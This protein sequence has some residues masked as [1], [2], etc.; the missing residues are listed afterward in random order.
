MLSTPVVCLGWGA[1]DGRGFVGVVTVGDGDG[2]VG[3]QCETFDGAITF[4][5]ADQSASMIFTPTQSGAIN[6]I[7]IAPAFVNTS[8]DFNVGIYSSDGLTK[9]AESNLTTITDPEGW[10]TLALDSEY[11]AD[12]GTPVKLVM[13][14]KTDTDVR[15]RHNGSNI[16][17][18]TYYA[19]DL[20]FDDAMPATLLDTGASTNEN[21][22]CI[23]GDNTP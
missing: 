19:F 18:V 7:H 16:A 14:N 10:T 21:D 6:Y 23:Y 2:F 12:T 8:S 11:T 17:E 22:M 13:A 15:P 9:L 20:T 3:N 5:Q 1:G 4:L